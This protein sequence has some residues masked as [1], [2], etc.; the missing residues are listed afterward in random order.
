MTTCRQVFNLIAPPVAALAAG[1]ATA[2]LGFLASLFVIGTMG[3]QAG[4]VVLSGTALMTPL[5]AIRAYHAAKASLE[6]QPLPQ[7]CRN[8]SRPI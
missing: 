3:A 6:R 5:M 7:I 1:A 2:G 8:C 4:A